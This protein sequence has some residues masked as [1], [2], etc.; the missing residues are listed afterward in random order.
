M[1]AGCRIAVHLWSESRLTGTL[2][3]VQHHFWHTQLSF[4]GVVIRM[5]IGSCLFLIGALKEKSAWYNSNIVLSLR[6][7]QGHLMSVGNWKRMTNDLSPECFQNNICIDASLTLPWPPIPSKVLSIYWVLW[8]YL[9][10]SKKVSQCDVMQTQSHFILPFHIGPTQGPIGWPT[11][12]IRQLLKISKISWVMFSNFGHYRLW[13]LV[14]QVLLLLV[15]IQSAL[16]VLT[17]Q[18]STKKSAHTV[19]IQC[20]HNSFLGGFFVFFVEHAVK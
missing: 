5:L 3:P 8:A 7:Y 16:A 17:C 20:P 19:K 10:Y 6:V 15:T 12:P 2:T 18:S 13:Q 9:M 4:G 14:L 11:F 1:A